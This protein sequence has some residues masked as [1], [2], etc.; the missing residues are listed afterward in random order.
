MKA[1]NLLLS[2]A[3]VLIALISGCSSDQSMDTTATVPVV[4]VTSPLNSA[5]NT[6]LDQVIAVTFNE[7]INPSTTQTVFTLQQGTTV[8]PGTVSTNGATITFTPASPLAPNTTYTATVTVSSVDLLG[9]ATLQSTNTW[10]FSTGGFV[11]PSV[12][13]T[14]PTP[15]ATGVFINKN[16]SATFNMPMNASTINGTTFTV[17][18]GTTPVAGNVSYDG[19]N[20]IFNP[21]VDFAINTQY[22]ATITTGA[23]NI[24]GTTIAKNYVWKFTTGSVLA[25]K[26]LSTDP[27]NNATN[28]AANKVI[29]I[30]FSMPMDVSTFTSANI[31]LKSGTTTILGNLTYNLTKDV[32]YF[33]PSSNLLLNTTYTATVTTAV[34]NAA[35]VPLANNY[36]WSF[37]TNV[38]VTGSLVDLKS[39]ARFGIISGV[40]VSNNAGFSQIRN[41]DVGISP[42]V[43]SSI[44][45]FPPAT[46]VNGAIYASDDIAPAGTAAMLTQAKKDLT[47]AYLFVEGAS[48][49]APIGIAGDQGG[50]TLVAG[51]YKSTSTLLV[52]NGNLTL[53]GS[54][55]DVWIFQIA[56][57]FTT[58][59]GAGGNIVLAGGALAK[60]VYWQT[61][62][63]ATI[64]NYT[65]FQ[66]NVLALQSI[67]MGSHATATGRML[68]RN[69]AVVMTD[70]NI[71]TKP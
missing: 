5:I 27:L 23:K 60:N 10:T 8:V 32:A 19:T 13:S 22:T 20:A 44:T 68:A 51:I 39:V 40:G 11:T 33:T 56:S 34:K 50:K 29:S 52:Q 70:T 9:H 6:P 45:G 47:D 3:I 17:M 59:G 28:V 67:T 2:L 35:G 46:I 31:T 66:G 65:N 15:N 26:V 43:R 25:A 62:S 4:N 57:A 61:G 21:N 41:M 16:V 54:A 18:Q 7:A 64:G 71:I 49:S 63:S 53:S 55:T 37:N 12:I 69:G 42:G 24:Q 1:K 30:N 58:V 14:D 36:I 38:P 48:Y